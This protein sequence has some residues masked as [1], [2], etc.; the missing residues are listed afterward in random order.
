MKTKGK[1]VTFYSYKGGVGRTLALANVAWAAALDGKKVVIIDFDLEAPGI[2]SIVPFQ[3]V[4]KQ[5]RNDLAAS[6]KDGGL[7]EL[8]LF[9]KKF[10]TVPSIPTYFSCPPIK[11]KRF[12]GNGC[13][14]IIPAGK[15][16][17]TFRKKLQSFHWQEFYQGNGKEFF[18]RF[19]DTILYQFDQPD[20]VLIDSRTGLTDIGGICT[21][22]L[23]DTLVV[24]T[25]LN[26]QNLSGSQ[27]IIESIKKHSEYRKEE[28]YC[29]M[30]WMKYLGQ[31]TGILSKK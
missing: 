5:F 2:S 8:I 1:F 14:F 17:D 26:N 16:D 7:F 13:I 18:L 19:R 4:M 10:H 11:D 28:N 27:M 30:V 15:E 29:W 3:N 12:Q 24:M 25:G 22:L 20:L 31:A 6:E 21:V 23:P 9:Y